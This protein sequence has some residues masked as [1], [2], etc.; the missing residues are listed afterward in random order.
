MFNIFKT[1]ILGGKV[2]DMGWILGAPPYQGTV[3]R[4]M[5]WFFVYQL[6]ITSLALH[7]DSTPW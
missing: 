5:F 2:S 3:Y 4:A 7:G 6:C 1:N